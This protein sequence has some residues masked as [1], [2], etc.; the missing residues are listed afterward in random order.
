MM[1][2]N[3]KIIFS[4]LA[5][6]NNLHIQKG[7][8]ISSFSLESEI[9]NILQKY[10]N[11]VDIS[12]GKDAFVLDSCSICMSKTSENTFSGYYQL[13]DDI[14]IPFHSKLENF[15]DLIHSVGGT[16]DDSTRI[17]N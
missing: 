9:Y 6:I 12:L 1:S 11:T 13:H 8:L 7:I 14:Y 10:I 15:R 16:L 3:A 17:Y 4:T 2:D 5:E